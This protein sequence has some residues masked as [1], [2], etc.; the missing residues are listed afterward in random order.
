MIP[1][2][3]RLYELGSQSPQRQM[4]LYNLDD[5]CCFSG[6]SAEEWGPAVRGNFDAVIDM[7]SKRHEVTAFHLRLITRDLEFSDRTV[8]AS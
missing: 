7:A 8:S 6:R 5:P 2:Y 1:D 4:A 3:I